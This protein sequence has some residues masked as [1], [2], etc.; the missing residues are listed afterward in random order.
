MLVVLPTFGTS[1][2][3]NFRDLEL[4]TGMIKESLIFLMISR[5]GSTRVA[6][7]SEQY[8][9]SVSNF[10]YFCSVYFL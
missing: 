2:S 8:K 10:G 1:G 5:F 9:N 3:D 6:K 7:V 4:L